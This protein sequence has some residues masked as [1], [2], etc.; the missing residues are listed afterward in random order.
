MA[1]VFMAGSLRC[2][3][4]AVKTETSGQSCRMTARPGCLPEAFRCFRATAD[5]AMMLRDL[6]AA[7]Q[8]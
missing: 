2:A 7:G 6:D 8:A 1:A 3:G 4:Q 5:Q